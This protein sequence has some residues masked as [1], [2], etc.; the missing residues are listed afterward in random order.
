MCVCVCLYV[1]KYEVPI[2]D[3]N[4]PPEASSRRS[5]DREL[6]RPAYFYQLAVTCNS[7]TYTDLHGDGANAVTPIQLYSD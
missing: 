4:T 1:T 7:P 5:T 2:T 3:I 6:D